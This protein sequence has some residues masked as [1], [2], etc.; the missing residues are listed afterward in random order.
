MIAL[1]YNLSHKILVKELFR[2]SD[3]WPYCDDKIKLDKTGGVVVED[4]GKVV[5]YLMIIPHGLR[6]YALLDCF[7]VDPEYTRKGLKGSKVALLLLKE[8]KKICK[9]RGYKK[10]VWI[11]LD[12]ATPFVEAVVKKGATYH[13][14]HHILTCNI[15][16]FKI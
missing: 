11:M 13:G 5:G 6:N 2:R 12:N 1:H 9:E 10:T 14:K 16:D 3:F 8:A 15:K 7:T 4:N